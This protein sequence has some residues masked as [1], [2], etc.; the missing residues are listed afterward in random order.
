MAFE[1]QVTKAATA[2]H[3]VQ[4]ISWNLGVPGQIPAATGNDVAIIE[5]GKIKGLYLFL[6]APQS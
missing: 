3:Q 4:H 1:F 5:N 6:D 2:N